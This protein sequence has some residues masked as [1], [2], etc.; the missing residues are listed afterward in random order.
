METDSRRLTLFDVDESALLPGFAGRW[1]GGG[2]R[3]RPSVS[4]DTEE[5][6]AVTAC[7]LKGG[8]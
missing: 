7:P 3:L 2:V 8:L 5:E 1:W 6:G 4:M